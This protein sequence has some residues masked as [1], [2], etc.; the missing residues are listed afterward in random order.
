MLSYLWDSE[1]T[2]NMQV[3]LSE[4]QASILHHV[5]HCGPTVYGGRQFPAI[6]KL[7]HYG[8]VSYKVNLLYDSRT[9]KHSC[10]YTVKA[11]R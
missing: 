2:K 4:A 8:L 11:K 10:T 7:A 6:K 1:G 3:T 9:R 5:T